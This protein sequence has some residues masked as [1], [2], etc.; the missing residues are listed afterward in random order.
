MPKMFRSLKAVFAAAAIAFT[1]VIPLN[2]AHS[3]VLWVAAPTWSNL[4]VKSEDGVFERARREFDNGSNLITSSETQHNIAWVRTDRNSFTAE[5]NGGVAMAGRK[6]QFVVTSDLAFTDSIDGA[7][8]IAITDQNGIADITVTLTNAP[9]DDDTVQVSL[10]TGDAPNVTTLSGN[11][12][13]VWQSAG[14]YPIIKLVGSGQG[15][16]SRCTYRN[17]PARALDLGAIGHAHECLNGDFQEY[18]WAWSV[19]KKDWLPEY[20]QV[21]VKS[22]K[23]G[24]TINLLYKVTDIWGTPLADKSIYLTVDNGCR[25][26]K[27]GNYDNNNNTDENGYVS[28]SVPNK[29]TL[30]SVKNN[31]FVNSDTHA[32]ESGFIALSIQPTTNELDES[33]DY[34]WPQIVTDVN[35]KSSAS[36]LKVL[37][38]GGH[39]VNTAGDYVTTVN[40]VQVT[41]PPQS[42]DTSDQNLDDTM[43]ANLQIT[44]MKNSLLKAVYSPDIR[45]EAT[46][47]GQ[48]AIFD[49]ARPLAG[50]ADS[51]K[52]S[53][54]LN[55]SYTYIQKIALM[56]TKTGTTTFK[57]FTGAEFKTVSMDCKNA[58]TDARNIA[59]VPAGPA[60]P[61]IA[62][63][64][65]F[66]VT[67]RWGSPVAGVTVRFSVTGN[68]EM[69]STQDQVTD[70]NGIASA[71]ITAATAGNQT[72]TATVQDEAQATQVAAPADAQKGLAAGNA[73]ANQT[74][75]WGAEQLTLSTSTK[76]VTMIFYNEQGNQATF[77][78]GNK[79]SYINVTLP[80][81]TVVKRITSKGRHSIRVVVG[82]LTR[83]ASLTVK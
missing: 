60:I 11:M 15:F 76:K 71:D 70:A 55:F 47:G 23:Y 37:S 38:R 24:S 58:L 34:M 80:L 61:T 42:V 35:I 3:D 17:Q 28:F 6:V 7:D 69:T 4:H 33:A 59:A 82:T 74:V 79:K 40:N 83:T 41:N 44:F 52:F 49:T 56:C 32:R 16:Q 67:D 12:G 30:S 36:T 77:Y 73:E 78:D 51:A 19:F 27:W 81:Q 62:T 14:Y 20:S 5:Y 57:I 63:K 65:S 1:F 25:L 13:V 64:S 75:R 43:V 10:S 31:S 53:S 66:K 68:G 45:V 54:P 72:V 29:N 48:A 50:L 26:C 39:D 46:N 8:N 9:N 18:T 22:Y 21:Y 2:A